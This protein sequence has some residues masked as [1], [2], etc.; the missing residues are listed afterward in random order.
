MVG[1]SLGE[2]VPKLCV[3]E[4]ERETEFVVVELTLT[5]TVPVTVTDIVRS[6]LKLLPVSL[7][8]R[9]ELVDKLSNCESVTEFKDE[10]V[11]VNDAIDGLSEAVGSSLAEYV[12]FPS[13]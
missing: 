12:I 13:D 4:L 2:R 10:Y 5:L 9:V 3:R 11:D 8:L 7:A 1:S 6:G